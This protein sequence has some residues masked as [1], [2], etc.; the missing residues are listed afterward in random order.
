MTV[1]EG[2]GCPVIDLLVIVSS[3]G[4]PENLARFLDA[5]HATATSTTHVHAAVDEDDPLL[6]GYD[7]EWLAH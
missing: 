1:R 7:R 6:T 4:R 5:V 2:A 3:R